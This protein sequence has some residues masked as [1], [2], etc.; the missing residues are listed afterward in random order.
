M[1]N[2]LTVFQGRRFTIKA[3]KGILPVIPPIASPTPTQTGTPTQTPTNTPT[4]TV[5][6]S[7][8]PTPTQTPTMGVTPTQ[9]RTPSNT[10]TGTPTR[11]PAATLTPTPT[12]SITSSPTP[13]P[14]VTPVNQTS[15]PFK[16][17][18]IKYSWNN[19][20]V[21]FDIEN[22]ITNIPGYV[23]NYKPVGFCPGFTIVDS[24]SWGGDVK[25]NTG[26]EYVAVD[27]NALSAI[28]PAATSIELG[29]SGQWATAFTSGNITVEFTTYSGG[30][31]AKAGTVLFATGPLLQ[32]FNLFKSVTIA[33]DCSI[34]PQT[35]GKVTFNTLNGTAFMQ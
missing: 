3:Q 4:P 32:T 21:D 15:Q 23:N 28:N 14:S 27:F 20:G 29:L 8:T 13:T 24:L 7:F 31:I 10:P 34:T 30:T 22:A 9:T 5:T 6:P 33:G 16:Y 26:S 11:T 17:M 2:L 25:G 19:T 18:I 35:F 12:P 1:S